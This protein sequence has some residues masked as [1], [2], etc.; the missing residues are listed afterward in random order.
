MNHYPF[1]DGVLAHISAIIGQKTIK[2]ACG[3]RVAFSAT[4]HLEHIDCEECR[5]VLRRKIADTRELYQMV[6]PL[7][8][9]L[10]AICN[11][12]VQHAQAALNR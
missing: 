10:E 12:T 4:A 7:T 11:A 9:E 2:S 8:P 6:S 1:D 3:K 5:T